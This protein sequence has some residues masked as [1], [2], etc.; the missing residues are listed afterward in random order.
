MLRTHRTKFIHSKPAP[1]TRNLR[2]KVSRKPF[3]KVSKASRSLPIKVK[4]R[5][6]LLFKLLRALEAILR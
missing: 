4:N 3:P 5:S 6:F 2:I 1:K